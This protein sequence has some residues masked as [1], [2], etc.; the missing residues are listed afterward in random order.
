MASSFIHVVAEDIIL[1][2]FYGCIVFHGVCVV[3]I[4][5]VFVF[6]FV[7]RQGL[8]QSPRL[9]C[10]GTIMAH[11]S[12]DFLGSGDP[13]TSASGAARST[14]MNHPAWLIFLMFVEMALTVL[15]GLVLNS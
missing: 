9:E 15:P 11:C 5:F 6:V 13:P 2:F 1:F 14:G 3:Y 12:L 10:T 8:A 4:L 7:L